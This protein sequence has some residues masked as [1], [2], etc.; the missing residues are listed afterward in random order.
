MSS[1]STQIANR[2]VRT[3]VQQIDA[4][5]ARVFTLL[6]PEMERHW[7][8]GWSYRM[9]HS[10]SGVA[11]FGAVFTTGDASEATVWVVT[12]HEAPQRVGFVRWQP[13]GLVVQIDIRL[14][15]QGDGSAVAITYTYTAASAAGETALARLD[16]AQWNEMMR[17]W[18]TS[19]NQWL[20]D[21]PTPA[22]S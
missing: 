17:F 15:P 19:M 2:V 20:H 18:E 4:P 11:E 5:P 13:D 21:H 3:H 12:D 16:V 14:S 6:C 7:L 1:A 9:I 8:P 22:V 10:R